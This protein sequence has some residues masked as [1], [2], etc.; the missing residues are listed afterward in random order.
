VQDGPEHVHASS[1][2]GDDG[3]VVAFALGT[4]AVVEGAAVG[5]SERGEGC[6]IEDALEGLVATGCAAQEAGLA[7]LAQHRG[8]ACGGGQRVGA[9]EAVDAADQRDEFG[10]ERGPHPRHRQDEGRIRVVGEP[11]PD[12]V[13]GGLEPVA[14]GQRLAGD[15]GDDLCPELR[16]GM[17]TVCACAACTASSA[18]ASRPRRPVAAFVSRRVMRFALRRGYPRARHNG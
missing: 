8:E 3:L 10:G 15:I 9:V 2:E 6:L 13:I 17:V 1:C 4:L 5:S 7:G 14:G 18:N 11:L 16:P 12:R